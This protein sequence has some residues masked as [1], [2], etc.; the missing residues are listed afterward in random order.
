MN[1]PIGVVQ[2][3]SPSHLDRR[4][5]PEPFWAALCSWH[6][7]SV[8]SHRVSDYAS[9]LYKGWI[10][11]LNPPPSLLSV[12][13]VI[14]SSSPLWGS[15]SHFAN[16]KKAM[17]MVKTFSVIVQDI[18]IHPKF[19]SQCDCSLPKDQNFPDKGWWT[20]EANTYSKALVWIPTI[21]LSLPLLPFICL[22]S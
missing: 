1:H 7:W 21:L 22:F 6:C 5:L 10:K 13:W 3:H 8:S 14:H 15:N 16:P 2:D 12:L 9:S 20:N 4:L 17:N 18:S 11:I 19:F